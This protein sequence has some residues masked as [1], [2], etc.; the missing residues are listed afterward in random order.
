MATAPTPWTAQRLSNGLSHLLDAN[1]NRVALSIDA[2]DIEL[3]LAAVA[4]YRA[5]PRTTS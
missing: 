5:P 3:I 1:G 2:D 4:A